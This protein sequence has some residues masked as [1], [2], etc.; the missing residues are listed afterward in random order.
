MKNNFQVVA[1]LF[2]LTVPE[3]GREMLEP[4]VGEN[5]T[6][7]KALGEERM[8]QGDFAGAVQHLER[9][10]AQSPHSLDTHLDLATAYLC[11]EDAPHAQAQFEEALR[12]A[13][14]DPEPYLGLSDVQKREGQRNEA[15]AALEQAAELQPSNP[16]IHFK[17]A[18][19]LRSLKF[20]KKAHRAIRQAIINAPDQSFY[21]FWAGDLLLETKEFDESLNAFRA[22]LELSPGDDLLFCRAA[23]A[24][25]GSSK[26]QE[27]IKSVRLASDLD[28]ENL[29]HYGMLARFLSEAGMTEEALAEQAKADKMDTYDRANLARLLAIVGLPERKTN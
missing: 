27:A 21:H 28:P 25:W 19:L 9:A 4:R 11:L 17:I 7:S 24:F 10:I 6:E 18:E 16:F 26:H 29:M 20:Y 15:L 2:G 13:G 8:L 5:S 3:V 22:A 23:L 14:D 12:I 1:E